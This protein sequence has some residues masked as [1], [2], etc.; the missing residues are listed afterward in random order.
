MDESIRLI[1]ATELNVT[2]ISLDKIIKATDAWLK[3]PAVVCEK[4]NASYVGQFCL[5]GRYADWVDDY[6]EVF[7][8]ADPDTSKG[9][10]NYFGLIVRDGTVYIT[11][12][13]C[14]AES[15]FAAIRYNGTYMHSR[16]RHDYRVHP[17]NPNVFIDGGRDYVRCG[18]VG[19]VVAIEIR[20]GK[21]YDCGLSTK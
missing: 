14:V 21:W 12:A 4:Y 10:S 6:A 5:K 16:Y 7:Y 1:D 3:D 9:H 17:D 8:V 11:N 15:P 13:A 2:P 19:T 18:M 20:D